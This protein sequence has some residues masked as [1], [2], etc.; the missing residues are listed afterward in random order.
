MVRL[1][2]R[3]DDGR[4][5]ERKISNVSLIAGISKENT[6]KSCPTS[7]ELSHANT[8][9]P[10]G[11]KKSG[12][13]PEQQSA[14]NC[15]DDQNEEVSFENRFPFVEHLF[16]KAGLSTSLTLPRGPSEVVKCETKTKSFS[17]S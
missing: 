6:C 10:N 17:C 3:Y 14:K 16:K 4:F 13:M 7:T 8:Q 11:E 5:D 15:T 12:D 1:L 2:S 9:F